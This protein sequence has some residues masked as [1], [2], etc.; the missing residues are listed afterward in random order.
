[1]LLSQLFP[2]YTQQKMQNGD[3]YCGI[4]AIPWEKL[5]LNKSFKLQINVQE[6]TISIIMDGYP[7]PMRW[8]AQESEVTLKG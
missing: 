2:C 3:Q 7:F 4:P 1:M 5:S 6:C 8:V